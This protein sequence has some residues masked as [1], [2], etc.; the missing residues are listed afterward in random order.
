MKRW[1]LKES[2]FWER[3]PFFRL[4]LPLVAGIVS[5]RYFYNT[6]YA[7]T[8][9]ITLALL[10]SLYGI[11]LYLSQRTI[12]K[13]VQFCL[14]QLALITIGWLSFY[15]TDIKNKAGWFGNTID[16]GQQYEVLITNAA[17]EKNKTWKYEVEV[18][19]AFHN[20]EKLNTVGK[21]F[22][23]VY[24]YSAPAYKEGDKLLLPDRW[25]RI[26]NSGNPFEFDYEQFCA[27][28]N[29]YYQQFLS[30]AD[31]ELL[32]FADENS[33]SPIRQI[34]NWCVAQ[35]ETY[36]SDRATL[37]L[38]EAI[39]VGERSLLDS[40]TTQNYANTGI[41][42]VIAISGA[43]ISIF[44]FLILFL[45]SGIK[46]RK[47]RWVKYLIALPLIWLYVLV[48]GAPASAV[49]AASMFSILGIGFA[50]QKQQNGINQLL[51]TAF[52]LLLV[53]PSWLFAAGFQLSF[54]AVLSIFLFYKPIYRLFSVPNK[55]LR[56]LWGIIAASIS[57]ELLIAPLVIYYFHLFPV[58]FILANIIAYFFMSAILILG[59]AI[60]AFSSLPVIAGFL[61]TI[62]VALVGY[63]NKAIEVLAPLNIEAFQ[64]LQINELELVL[65]YLAIA[66]CVSFILKKK[67]AALM[68]GIA[69]IVLLVGMLIYQSNK[70]LQQELLVVY[71]IN[72]TGYIE[73]ISGKKNYVVNCSKELSEQSEYYVLRPAH[74]RWHAWRTGDSSQEKYS[75]TIN[76]RNVLIV[77]D[78]K[79][80]LPD[81]TV[82]ILI[83]N[84][85]IKEADLQDLI[86]RY[87]P[88]QLVFSSILTRKKAAIWADQKE[89]LQIP[90]HITGVDGAYILS[91]N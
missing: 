86:N 71:N 13:A 38:L 80:I 6:E 74:T 32:E 48:A 28:N 31:I 76:N 10:I 12:V 39:L 22:L 46:H 56:T 37:G 40:T 54:L 50:F 17:E 21:A 34:H 29:I 88:Q 81:T 66:A 67:K 82:Q 41:V 68:L 16:T 11:S 2:Y 85:N 33:L 61:S 36:I 57:A 9:S 87:T 24:K 65:V 1:P 60:I 43:H 7:L 69:S 15:Q 72:R 26:K 62:T 3:T 75:F 25:Q 55:P 77:N 79:Q 84:Y 4:L 59:M 90:I 53:Q 89:L 78:K 73:Y 47:Y 63:F 30:G 64:Y 91:N 58:Q 42:H 51:A 49:R 83:I 27:N 19:H 8:L 14:V 20:K 5:Y 18:L 70:A 23:Y 52:I 45:M 44:F 35:L